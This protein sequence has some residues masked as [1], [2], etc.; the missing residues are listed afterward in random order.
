MRKLSLSESN[1]LPMVTKPVLVNQDSVRFLST[2]K[3]FKLLLPSIYNA[4]IKGCVPRAKVMLYI[5][6]CKYGQDCF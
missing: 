5:P 1:N 2:S 3:W 4:E 6:Q